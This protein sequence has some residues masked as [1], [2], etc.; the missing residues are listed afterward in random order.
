MEKASTF[1]ITGGDQLVKQQV[2]QCSTM[3]TVLVGGNGRFQE[4]ENLEDYFMEYES[5]S[6]I[7]KDHLHFQ[8]FCQIK[9]NRIPRHHNRGGG[10]IHNH[11]LHQTIGRFFLPNFDGSSKCTAKSWVENLD[12]YF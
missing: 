4:Q 11:D 3:P 6:H 2:S 5:Q 10:F 1:L 8:E 12:M 9:D 7:F